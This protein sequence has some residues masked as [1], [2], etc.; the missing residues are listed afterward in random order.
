M[1]AA[2]QVKAYMAA[3][4]TFV[5][6]LLDFQDQGCTN[7]NGYPDVQGAQSFD[8]P[9]GSFSDERA[10]IVH[11]SKDEARQ[12]YDR[13]HNTSRAEPEA[14]Q[15][16]EQRVHSRIA[17]PSAPAMRSGPRQ[18]GSR[19]RGLP[20]RAGVGN[21]PYGRKRKPPHGEK[22]KPPQGE[23]SKPPQGETSMPH[24]SASAVEEWRGD[25]KYP[26]PDLNKA[27][28]RSQTQMMA[29]L[30]KQ[31]QLDDA[32]LSALEKHFASRS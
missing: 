6:P 4:H 9:F 20:P 27:I 25:P 32:R 23:T 31:R 16:H 22:S 15:P 11:D 30:D 26:P 17:T 8:A 7:Y 3:Q 12:W 28:M 5:P 2:E 18:N 21:F 13:R 10:V 19:S 24:K 29:E 14:C 1:A